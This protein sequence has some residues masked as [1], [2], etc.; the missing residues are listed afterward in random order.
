M[1]RSVNGYSSLGNENDFGPH[2]CG[3]GSGWVVATLPEVLV[4]TSEPGSTLDSVV[5]TT[6]ATVVDDACVVV[7][8]PDVDEATLSDAF[9]ELEHADTDTTAA[10]KTSTAMGR[11]RR[12]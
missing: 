1:H 10:A 9:V 11:D 2:G 6:P 8:P 5:L 3:R 12:C 4:D 7:D